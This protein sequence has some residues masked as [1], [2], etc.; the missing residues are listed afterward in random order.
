MDDPRAG[1]P[2]VHAVAAGRRLEK[3]ENLP[4]GLDAGGQVVVGALGPDDEVVAVDAGGDVGPCQV[5]GHEL[6]QGHLRRCV[7][8]VDAVGLEPQV[9]LAA[10]VAS[11]V[12]VAEQRLLHVVQVAVQD[13]LGQS[14]PLPAQHPPH[15]GVLVEQALVRRRQRRDA[16]KLS[17]GETAEAGAGARAG[18]ASSAS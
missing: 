16:G 18:N 13:L 17:R 7:L 11:I 1:G 5:A 4:V 3:V 9:G 10:D 2:K 15:L 6:Q 12:R 8:H 14:Q